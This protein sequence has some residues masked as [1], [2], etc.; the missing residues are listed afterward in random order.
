M[1]EK[2]AR[3]KKIP[4]KA[5][6]F[7]LYG[8][9]LYIKEKT[10]PYYRLF[11][12]WKVDL[13]KAKDSALTKNWENLQEL[14]KEW[15]G[16]QS[17]NL[18]LYQKDLEAEL[19][20]TQLYCETKEVLEEL[21]NRGIKIGVISNLA[22]PYRKPF[23][24][25]GLDQLVDHYIF[26]CDVGVKKPSPEIYQLMIDKWSFSPA[27]ILMVGDSPKCDFLGP[28]SLG[29]NA[30]LLQRER[31]KPSSISSLEKIL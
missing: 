26:S 16:N 8:T 10:N 21:R 23:F 19:A 11:K 14:A 30:I 24:D 12:K 27:E 4:R 7:D 17:V 25:L 15:G 5:V 1:K 2:F 22:S 6:I 3:V 18:E 13:R 29:I 9:L 31:T 28:K 20:S